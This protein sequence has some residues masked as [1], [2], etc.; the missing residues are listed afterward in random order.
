MR[1]N[2]ALIHTISLG[3]PRKISSNYRRRLIKAIY[4][5]DLH[6]EAQEISAEYTNR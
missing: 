2:H 5:Y 3:D 1:N 6:R 4:A